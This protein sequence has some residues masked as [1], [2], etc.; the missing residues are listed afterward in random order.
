MK[1]MPPFSAGSCQLSLRPDTSPFCSCGLKGSVVRYSV[2]N[3]FQLKTWVG[4]GEEKFRQ[5]CNSTEGAQ[6]SLCTITSKVT[7]IIL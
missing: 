5:E 1:T 2:P 7:R 3:V 6:W 4:E